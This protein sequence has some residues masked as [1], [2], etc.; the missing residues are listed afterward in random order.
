MFLCVSMHGNVAAQHYL[1]NQARFW[2]VL[3]LPTSPRGFGGMLP[4]KKIF[5][6]TD[7]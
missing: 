5:G 2:T 7:Q 1:A 3:R 6:Y 4:L